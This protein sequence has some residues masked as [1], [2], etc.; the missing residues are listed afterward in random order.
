MTMRS[1]ALST[2]ALATLV[3]GALAASAPD[4]DAR[5][6]RCAPPTMDVI[7][8]VDDPC[9]C[10][11]PQQVCV[12]VPCCCTEPPCVAWRNGAFKRRIATY[13]WPCCGYSVEVV[14]THKGKL[15]VR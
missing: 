9:D 6:R 10:C 11:A 8:C 14:V 13:S 3:V 5:A 12:S 7:L 15:I 1:T 2:F 4:A